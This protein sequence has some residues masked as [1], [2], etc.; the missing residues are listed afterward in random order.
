[1]YRKQYDIY[2]YS[3]INTEEPK[4]LIHKYCKIQYPEHIE[5]QLEKVLAY[6]K[7]HH[8]QYDLISHI[9]L[10]VRPPFSEQYGAI[11]DLFNISCYYMNFLV[12]NPK[13]SKQLQ[14]KLD[15]TFPTQK[16][17]EIKERIHE[18][19][20]KFMKSH[21]TDLPILSTLIHY[22]LLDN[23]LDKA[24]KYLKHAKNISS[25]YYY[26]S[27]GLK[28]EQGKDGYEKD[29]DK[30]FQCYKKSCQYFPSNSSSYTN[31]GI[32]Y[33][34]H[35]KDV[36]KAIQCL[37]VAVKYDYGHWNYLANYHLAFIMETEKDDKETA[38][39]HYSK[40]IEINPNHVESHSSLGSLLL[41][42]DRLDDALYHY[43]IACKYGSDKP[44]VFYNLANCY[45]RKGLLELAV[46][47]MDK[48]IRLD[49]TSP[50]SHYLLSN[51][52]LKHEDFEAAISGY[53]YTIEV[54]EKYP[55]HQFDPN[56]ALNHMIIAYRL[57]SESL[58]RDGKTINDFKRAAEL[59]EES[60][61]LMPKEDNHAY[62][63]TLLMT[64][65]YAY[66]KSRNPKKSLETMEKAVELGGKKFLNQ[67]MDV[68]EENASLIVYQQLEDHMEKLDNV[69][70]R[71]LK[72]KN[73]V[74]SDK[75]RFDEDIVN[76]LYEEKARYHYNI[77]F[78]LFHIGSIEESM[79]HLKKTIDDSDGKYYSDYIFED[80]EEEEINT[81]EIISKPIE[82]GDTTVVVSSFPQS[83]ELQSLLLKKMK[84]YSERHKDKILEGIDTPNKEA[85]AVRKS[86][87]KR[88]K[89]LKYIKMT[90]KT[91]KKLR[92]MKVEGDPY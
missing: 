84:E 85:K 62:T 61:R 78:C 33:Y 58:I 44:L 41:D 59:M 69:A 79:K 52:L 77:A 74:E 57:F 30:A 71:I 66:M 90:S 65:S 54:S 37:K 67:Y 20:E 13:F 43:K 81:D 19:E 47:E 83:N 91:L 35:Y 11:I 40:A 92:D 21:H 3:T 46:N 2:F 42:E 6:P 53:K 75:I 7:N 63:A 22:Y 34:Y 23:Q 8:L 60:I 16:K 14:Y 28:Y 26:F 25:S 27:E 56:M 89:K 18:Y 82:I 76:S 86:K 24:S 48:A 73:D 17:H 72:Y 29:F 10:S 88:R 32:L 31:L 9:L 4:S 64:L 68:K 49:P 80:G 12:D 87:T 50:L 38:K 15:Q 55:E 39:K 1:M 70:K 45:S 5:K 51:I 36:D